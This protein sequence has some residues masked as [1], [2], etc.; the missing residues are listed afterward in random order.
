MVTPL[1]QAEQ[2]FVL[3]MPYLDESE[4]RSES[5]TSRNDEGFPKSF[6]SLCDE[7]RDCVSSE[8]VRTLA[9]LHIE[10]LVARL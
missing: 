9:D 10:S 5:F 6:V 1:R 8:T 2:I 4:P 3:G 7:V